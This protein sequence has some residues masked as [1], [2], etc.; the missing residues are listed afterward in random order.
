MEFGPVGTTLSPATRTVGRP[1]RQQGCPSSGEGGQRSP[2][3]LAPTSL[4]HGTA[5]FSYRETGSVVLVAKG[6]AFPEAG[7]LWTRSPFPFQRSRGG[8]KDPSPWGTGG[9]A[10]RPSV[11]RRPVTASRSCA[12]KVRHRT[13]SDPP[14]SP[15]ALPRR[16]RGRVRDRPRA[17]RW[18]GGA[19]EWAGRSRVGLLGPETGCRGEGAGPGGGGP[20]LGRGLGGSRPAACGQRRPPPP[21]RSP[22]FPTLGP[23]WRTPTVLCLLALKI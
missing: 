17:G 4:P 6:T 21:R 7:G 3:P 23:L 9:D 22:R 20:S 14:R 11:T 15:R 12:R 2:P 13:W 5:L 8:G 19:N 18:R 1:R 10:L 16:G